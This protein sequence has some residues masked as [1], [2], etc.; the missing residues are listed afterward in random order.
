MTLQPLLADRTCYRIGGQPA[1]LYS[2][3]FH[4]FRVP[5]KEW[6]RRMRLFK[7][8]GGNCLATYVPWLIHEPEEGHFAF[9]GKGP[10][11]L[12]G[13]LDTA[14]EEGLYV[15]AR[16]G[17]YQYS[18]LKYDGLASWVCENYPELHAHT[19][20][21]ASFRASSISYLHPLF[22][23]KVRRWFAEVCP[24]LARHTVSRGGPVAFVQF[25]NELAGIHVWFGGLDYNVTT[26]GFGQPAGRWPAFLQA[27]YTTVD[28]LN[29]AYGAAHTG[30]ADVRPPKPAPTGRPAEI[31]RQRDYFQFYLGTLAEYGCLLAAMM[32]EHGIDVPFVHNAANPGMN[33]W[34]K[35]LVERIKEPFV[36]GSDHYYTLNQNWAQN[37][38]TP[39]YAIGVFTS[40]EMLRVMGFPPTVHELPGG[41]LSDW[42]PITP[43]DA[44][45]CYLTNVAFGMKG[46]NFYILTGG[47]NLPGTGVTSDVY[48][49]G[50]SIG[51][52]GEVRP[53]YSVQKEVGRYLKRHAWLMEGERE[54][55]CR[56]TLDFEQPVAKQYWQADGDFLF[57][58]GDAWT[59][60][61]RGILTT[62]LCSGLSPRFVDVDVED[63]VTDTGTP[64]I[65]VAC[66]SMARA[67]QER[68]VRFLEHGGKVLLTPVLPTHDE[69][70]EPCTV[71]ADYLGRPLIHRNRAQ[72][73]RVTVA[74]V[75]NVLNNGD[76]YLM[77]AVP[78]GASA[79]GVEEV[80]GKPMAVQWARTGG[81]MAL[82]LGMRWFH[83][84][85][86]HEAMLRGV[87]KPLGIRPRIRCS[88]PNVW[89]AVRTAGSRSVVFVMNLLS[90]PMEA[91]V[92]CRPEWSRRWIDVGHFRLP[93]MSVRMRA[94][95]EG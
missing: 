70:L 73:S 21:G 6:R 90:A 36:L 86:E 81:G 35:P 52:R 54:Y 63:W 89:V 79:L 60:T 91:D 2:G 74:G 10:L 39:Q 71:L 57:S 42:P 83:A 50:A 19:W 15:I 46:S 12:E 13:F 85:R 16:P 37:N 14:A 69:H 1:Y 76:V 40:L 28:A 29:R 56:V 55:D 4:Y 27:R 11:D 41:S 9:G 72:F 45:A 26:M 65:V 67:R 25:D 24:R 51:A 68:L 62:A 53:L 77:E 44:R 33:A 80:T 92:S 31:R 3:E 7:A 84:M 78:R 93:A 75:T 17:P 23:E 59:F 34:F 88:N 47:P 43:S 5:R 18:E 48:D 49:Y 64:L 8:A 82:W 38:P 30:F 94:V 87:L 32:R 95:G 66:A 20:D 61:Q 58:P 22:L